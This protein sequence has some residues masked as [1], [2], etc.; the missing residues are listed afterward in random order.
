MLKQIP[1]EA[2]LI[3][4]REIEQLCA[5]K[6]PGGLGDL[7]PEESLGQVLTGRHFTIQQRF[8]GVDLPRVKSRHFG[9]AQSGVSQTDV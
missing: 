1:Q 9:V 3:M 6:S 4:E 2:L 5:R 7:L 8:N